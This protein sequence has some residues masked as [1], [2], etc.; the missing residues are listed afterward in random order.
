M[1]STNNK[2]VKTID[3]YKYWNKNRKDNENILDREK[4]ALNLIS[5][6]SINKEK[7]N[8]LDAGCG[9]GKFMSVLMNNPKMDVKGIDYSKTEVSKLRKKG[10][11]VRQGDF[12]KG[13][14]LKDS[15]FDIIYAGEV[16]EHL[17]NPDLLIEES[18]R[19][20]K[21]DGFLII[22]TPNLCAWFNRILMLFGMQPIFIEP[23]TKSKFVGAGFLKRFKKDPHPVGHVR[24]FT[25]PA[26]KDMLK[27]YGFKIISIK[28]GNFDEGFPKQLLLIDNLF[29]IVPSLSSHL[30]IAAKKI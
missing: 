3:F 20:L 15:S 24:I 6:I 30:I 23:S 21:K 9:N 7:I 1:N 19:L 28:G 2:M 4:I 29:K 13:I 16:I 14:H 8:F 12:E 26:L 18:N 11:D 10:F 27:M 17:Y 22:S 25:L 5:K